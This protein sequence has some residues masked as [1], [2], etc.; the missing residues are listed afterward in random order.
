[1]ACWLALTAPAGAQPAC[2][3]LA[4][5]DA[6]IKRCREHPTD[7]ALRDEFVALL[8]EAYAAEDITELDSRLYVAVLTDTKLHARL[9]FL[10]FRMGTEKHSSAS[11]IKVVTL[12]AVLHEIEAGRLEW[13]SV[14]E[15]CSVESLVYRM[16]KVSSNEA[17]NALTHYLGFEKINAWLRELGFSEDEL[18][19]GHY[20]LPAGNANRGR[21]G[22]NRSTAAGMAK[23]FF[24]IAQ[25]DD[26][27]GFLSSEGLALAR[28]L[29]SCHNESNNDPHHNDRLNRDVAESICF[30]H[31][32]GN[33]DYVVT[34]GGIFNC[35]DRSFIVVVFDKRL[36]KK[37]MRTFGAA[38]VEFSADFPK[39][40]PPIAVYEFDPILLGP[41]WDLGLTA[42]KIA[43][44]LAL[45]TPA[46]NA[47]E[48]ASK[49]ESD[50]AAEPE[51]EPE[52]ESESQAEP[53]PEHAE[54]SEADE[55][56]EEDCRRSFRS[57]T[58]A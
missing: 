16:I 58:G 51:P 54:E 52:P 27:D 14:I 7:C 30:M 23:L 21:L 8:Q 36:S 33:N 22:T 34:D 1:M 5:V 24:L 38:L 25:E 28:K 13:E 57:R 37:K 39:R 42:E 55:R 32:T 50:Q 43:N 41:R 9:E 15:G 4:Q 3:I 31:K 2:E 19:I 47:T 17:Y 6:V 44:H 29:L 45:Q 56:K 48:S 18:F 11:I 12:V 20:L 40:I 35:G 53:E 10:E 26:V 49:S 46:P